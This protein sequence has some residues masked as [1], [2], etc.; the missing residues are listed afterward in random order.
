MTEQDRIAALEAELRLVKR[1]MIRM[2]DLTLKVG[3]LAITA[4]DIS[5]HKAAAAEI[6]AMVDGITSLLEGED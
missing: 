2:I 4:D 5:D 1:A 3:T 6:S